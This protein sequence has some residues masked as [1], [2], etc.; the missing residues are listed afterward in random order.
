M[1]NAIMVVG[2]HI[3]AFLI[4]KIDEINFHLKSI[5]ESILRVKQKIRL[6][7]SYPRIQKS[8]RSAKSFE[9]FRKYRWR[10]K[11]EHKPNAIVGLEGLYRA[12]NKL[13]QTIDIYLSKRRDTVSVKRFFQKFFNLL[14][15]I[16]SKKMSLIMQDILF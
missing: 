14:K 3:F 12:V 9:K 13:D 2:R 7:R 4:S 16:I 5:F 6:D 10:K 1:K 15:N 11:N 8:Y